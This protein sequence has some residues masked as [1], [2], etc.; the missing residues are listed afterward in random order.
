MNS[1]L[2]CFFCFYKSSTILM[3][4][5]RSQSPQRKYIFEVLIETEL[6]HVILARN[7][8]PLETVPAH[9]VSTY[10]RPLRAG[11]DLL[12][13]AVNLSP[14]A[15]CLSWRRPRGSRSQGALAQ[16]ARTHRGRS[17]TQLHSERGRRSLISPGNIFI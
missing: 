16:S 9:C 4:A 13:L 3:K 15:L 14:V 17:A 8:I 6:K 7:L 12:A 1:T 11:N 5:L 2:C 10:T